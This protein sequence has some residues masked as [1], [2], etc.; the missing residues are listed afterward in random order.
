MREEFEAHW[1]ADMELIPAVAVRARASPS[2]V[3][4]AVESLAPH[5]SRTCALNDDRTTQTPR[6]AV[7][8]GVG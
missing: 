7:F 4:I 3:N 1:R 5:I 6:K 2:N 8:Y